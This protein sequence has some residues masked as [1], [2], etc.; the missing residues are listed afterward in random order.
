MHDVGGKASLYLQCMLLSTDIYD[1]L[2]EGQ[3]G[4]GEYPTPFP[5]WPSYSPS[6]LLCKFQAT[7]ILSN[8]GTKPGKVGISQIQYLECISSIFT[9]HFPVW[10]VATTPFTTVQRALVIMVVSSIVGKVH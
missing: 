4:L 5:V 3:L 2:P 1:R 8:E 10:C 7:V 6:S 9:P